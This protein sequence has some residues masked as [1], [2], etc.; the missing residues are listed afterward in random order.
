[1]PRLRTSAEWII[2]FRA[3]NAAWEHIPWERGAE[4]SLDAVL[5]LLRSLQAWQLGETSEARRLKAAARRHAEATGDLDF[6][7]AMDLFILEEQRHGESIGRWLDAVGAERIRRDWGDSLFRLFRHARP[8]IEVWT[9]VVVVIEVL[10]VVYYSSVR[11]AIPSPLLKAVCGQILRD[12]IP[13]L[14][15]QSERLARIYRGR[16]AW[17]MRLTSAIQHALFAGITLVVWMAHRRMFVAGGHSFAT[18]WRQASQQMRL[19]RLRM[20]TETTRRATTQRELK[21]EPPSRLEGWLH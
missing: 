14:E 1:M 5:P 18:Y 17:R 13:H 7:T 9:T 3:N 20:R 2:Y 6:I 12:E 21:A 11:R 19:A 15:F 4:I 8:D 10:A 16:S